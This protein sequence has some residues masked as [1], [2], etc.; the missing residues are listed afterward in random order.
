ME[1]NLLGPN[2]SVTNAIFAVPQFGQLGFFFDS[3][4]EYSSE[5]HEYSSESHGQIDHLHFL[6]VPGIC[7]TQTQKRLQ[8]F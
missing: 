8:Q 4:N 2:G 6:Q 5:I 3:C 1:K 7:A